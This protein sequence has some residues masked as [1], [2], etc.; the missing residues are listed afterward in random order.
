[1]PHRNRPCLNSDRG[2]QP[3]HRVSTVTAERSHSARSTG[4]VSPT[5]VSHTAPRVSRA[6]SCRS[7]SSHLRKPFQAVTGAPSRAVCVS[8]PDGPLSAPVRRSQKV[9]AGQSQQGRL[10]AG[11]CQSCRWCPTPPGAT[12]G[13]RLNTRRRGRSPQPS[14]GSRAAQRDRVP[15]SEPAADA[16]VAGQKW[17]ILRPAEW[18]RSSPP[19]GESAPGC[20]QNCCQTAKTKGRRNAPALVRTEFG[21]DGR[22]RTAESGF[23]RPLP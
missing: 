9:A 5:P 23:C 21:G 4:R 22:I 3:H 20:C 17:A 15:C 18:L 13:P 1:M 19:K 7:G 14:R 10:R 12:Q 2:C 8:K 11:V 6:P 16:G